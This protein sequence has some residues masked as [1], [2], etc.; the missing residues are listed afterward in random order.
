M[1]LLNR[2]A[3][4]LGPAIPGDRNCV[5]LARP[6]G[7]D[8]LGSLTLA[9]IWESRRDPET[10]VEERTFA[11]VTCPPNAMMAKIHTRMPVI[12]APEDYA[13]WLGEE[14]DPRDLLKPFPSEK[15][16]MWPIST[17]VNAPAHDDPSILDPVPEDD[18]PL[19]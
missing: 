17:R 15:M 2:I 7:N 3:R 19:L 10:G 18:E 11:V 16:T 4:K 13:R 8:A 5:F 6:V 14:P 12:L 9:A 1:N